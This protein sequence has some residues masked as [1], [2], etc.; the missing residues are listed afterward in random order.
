M[1]TAICAYPYFLA[2]AGASQKISSSSNVC[3]CIPHSHNNVEAF[4]TVLLDV[5]E[6]YT[7][8][9]KWNVLTSLQRWAGNHA[10]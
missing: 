10:N 5:I 1:V 2:A 3:V 8:R 9:H 7:F 4:P 6:S